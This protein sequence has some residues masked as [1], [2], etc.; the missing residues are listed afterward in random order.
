MSHLDMRWSRVI[1]CVMTLVLLTACAAK[2]PIIKGVAQLS[3]AASDDMARA[4]GKQ[5]GATFDLTADDAAR[6]ATQWRVDEAVIRRVAPVLDEQPVWKRTLAGVKTVY[7]QIPDELRSNIAGLACEGLTGE[8]TTYSELVIKLRER[9]K[10]SSLVQDVA[11][12]NAVMELWQ[13]LS[14]ASRDTSQE[15]R[16]AGALTCFGVEQVAGLTEP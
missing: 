12:A 14:E 9:F 16:A 8:I 5:L 1:A 3:R 15:V 13:V 7:E 11:L 2:E 6:M 10:T 4:A